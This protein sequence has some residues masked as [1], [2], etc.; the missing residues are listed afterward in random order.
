MCV[1]V[2]TRVVVCVRVDARAYV[3]VHVSVDACVYTRVYV[4]ICS[5][6][7]FLSVMALNYGYSFNFFN[8]E[9]LEDD[10]ILTSSTFW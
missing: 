4:C 10:F 9:Q 5:F 6:V 2:N 1:C 8:I 7:C 3:Y